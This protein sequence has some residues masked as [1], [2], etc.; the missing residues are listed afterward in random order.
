MLG[1]GLKPWNRAEQAE[2]VGARFGELRRVD[3]VAGTPPQYFL[4]ADQLPQAIDELFDWYASQRR[5]G[6]PLL[7]V[8]AQMQQRLLTLHP[9][10]DANGRSARL[11]LDWLLL[12]AELPVPV[13][14]PA[15]LALF[16]NEAATRQVAPGTA[17]RRLLEGLIAS[18]DLHV[19]WLGLADGASA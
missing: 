14:Q 10:A 13:L 12:L 6:T 7:L 15:D 9:F 1:E 5:F 8:A 4:R 17:E 18:I 2:R 11:V 3:V 16:P 19:D